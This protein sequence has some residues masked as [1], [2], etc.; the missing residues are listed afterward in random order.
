MSWY[1]LYYTK[2]IYTARVY[3]YLLYSSGQGQIVSED[4]RKHIKRCRRHYRDLDKVIEELA[5]CNE[6]LEDIIEK[7]K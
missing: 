3:G 5:M 1:N 6:D 7:I 2:S 4:A